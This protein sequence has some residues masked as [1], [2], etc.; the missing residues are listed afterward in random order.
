M[1]KVRKGGRTVKTKE[2]SKKLINLG[3]TTNDS[4]FVLEKRN[5]VA[6]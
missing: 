1:K 2:V 3:G 4:H 6:F 5:E